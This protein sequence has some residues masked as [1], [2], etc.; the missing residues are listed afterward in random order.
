MFVMMSNFVFTTLAK[1]PFLE[2]AQRNL[3][4]YEKSKAQG[5]GLCCTMVQKKETHQL[6][7]CSIV[8]SN[9]VCFFFNLKEM[10]SEP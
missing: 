3:F 5:S 7:I 8:S 2:G 4:A 6:D 9:L 10:E 1:F